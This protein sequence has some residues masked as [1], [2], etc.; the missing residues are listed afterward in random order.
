MDKKFQYQARDSSG[1][2]K[3]GQIGAQSKQEAVTK[4]KAMGLLVLSL[5]EEKK[6]FSLRGYLDKLNS[7]EILPAKVGLKDK[8]IFCRQLSSMLSSGIPIVNGLQSLA[9][10][11]ENKTLKGAVKDIAIEIEKGRSFSAA[12]KQSPNIFSNYFIKL[13]EVGETGGFLDETLMNLANYF[14]DQNEK[15]KEIISNISYPM[16]TMG[17]SV[18]VLI[19][20]M[21]KVLPNFMKT[22]EKLN[23]ELPLPTKILLR[24]SNFMSSYWWLLLIG[25]IAIL[26]S[27]YYYYQTDKGR[28]YIDNLLLKV[29]VLKDFILENSLIIFA[30]NLSLLERSGIPFLQGMEIVNQNIT[31]RAIQQKLDK[32][33]LKIK[34]GFNITTALKQQDIFPDIALQ[35][36]QT[37]E[38]TGSLE[39]KLKDIVDFYQEEVEE[40]FARIVALLEPSL[41]IFLT[42]GIGGIVASVILPIFKM[43]QGY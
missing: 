7:I 43:S 21:V 3:S 34:D 25:L 13:V 41:I 11:V 9:K 33:R 35:M 5:D 14:K 1:R 32:A 39:E 4:L 16:I 24:V 38:N 8:Y 10:Q 6:G 29:P 19:L 17:S 20:M 22:F 2:K 31:N 37:A 12:L 28:Y 30:K 15:R 23:V 40:K 27:L 26:L 18:I 42:F 36:I